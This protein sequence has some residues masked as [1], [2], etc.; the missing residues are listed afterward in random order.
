MVFGHE[1]VFF[2]SILV[3]YYTSLLSLFLSFFW[4]YICLHNGFSFICV[5]V[6]YKSLCKILIVTHLFLCIHLCPYSWIQPCV[7]HLF[8][9]IHLCP[10]SWIQLC[11]P[12]SFYPFIFVRALGYN[13][14]IRNKTCTFYQKKN[15]HFH[16]IVI[17][18]CPFPPFIIILVQ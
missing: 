8:L 2:L 12:I 17:C 10:Y 11:V 7:P 5:V 9:S 13:L 14:L 1:F 3:L 16:Y 6:M 18:K 15:I 4:G